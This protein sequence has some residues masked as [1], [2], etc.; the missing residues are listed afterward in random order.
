M[1]IVLKYGPTASDIKY[2]I[3]S[4][5]IENV[6]RFIPGNIAFNFASTLSQLLQLKFC[7][8]K[9]NA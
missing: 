8:T 3:L 6:S 2:E 4:E 1:F 7:E 9:R 5:L